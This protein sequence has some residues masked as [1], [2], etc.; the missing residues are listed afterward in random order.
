MP[1]GTK[2]LINENLCRYYK[3]FWSK[4]EKLFLEKKIP[5]FWASNGLVKINLSIDQVCSN[6]HEVDL[7]ASSHESPFVGAGRNE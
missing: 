7:L 1:S 4:C 2:V 3:L 5:S 6:A